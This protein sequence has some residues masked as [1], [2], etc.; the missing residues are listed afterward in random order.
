MAANNMESTP[1]TVVFTR[2]WCASSMLSAFRALRV[3]FSLPDSMDW[4]AAAL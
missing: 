1:S 4:A 2:I 3:S